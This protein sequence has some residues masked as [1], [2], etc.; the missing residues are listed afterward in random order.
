MQLLVAMM[1]NIDDAVAAANLNISA[2]IPPIDVRRSFYR[3]LRTSWRRSHTRGEFTIA[4]IQ[5]VPGNVGGARQT[6]RK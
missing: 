3:R 6:R 5:Q 4:F 2:W 1:I